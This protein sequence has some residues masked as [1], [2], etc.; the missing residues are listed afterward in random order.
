MRRDIGEPLRTG[1]EAAHG[2]CHQRAGGVEP[3][4]ALGARELP[5]GRVRIDGV[6]AELTHVPERQP[7]SAGER[8]QHLDR[9]LH[10]ARVR[11][12]GIIDQP[13]PAAGLLELQAARHGAH[14]GQARG[15]V[16]KARPRAA[17]RRG[18]RERIGDVVRAADA[19]LD[20]GAA[21]GRVQPELR[22]EAVRA[23]AAR[24]ALAL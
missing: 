18:R 1:A 5:D 7:T 19:Q 14:R 23:T 15:D 24:S 8:H 2:A 22:A 3:L 10:R 20:A 12:V 16:R 11:V 21:G 9:S 17:S 13:G 4:H 6:L